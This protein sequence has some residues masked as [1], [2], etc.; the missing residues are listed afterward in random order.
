MFQA[1]A[2]FSGL[3]RELVRKMTDCA[4]N[5]I[6]ARSAK[7]DESHFGLLRTWHRI[8]NLNQT[9]EWPRGRNA[10]QRALHNAFQNPQFPIVLSRETDPIPPKR[11]QTAQLQ[12]SEERRV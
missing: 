3:V 1:V 11:N 12:R 5:A 6:I 8:P 2:G 10:V 9:C 7:Y 4:R